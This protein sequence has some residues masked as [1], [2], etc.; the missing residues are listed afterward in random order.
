MS[1][2]SKQELNQCLLT[3][4]LAIAYSDGYLGADEGKAILEKANQLF[5]NPKVA[6]SEYNAISEQLRP[7]NNVELW[8]LIAEKIENFSHQNLL[9][10]ELENNLSEIIE[11][12]GKVSESELSIYRK[13]FALLMH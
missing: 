1:N 13:V 7:L 9:K 8:D 11:A 5:E 6:L 4:Y 2:P 10:K 3:I 12:D